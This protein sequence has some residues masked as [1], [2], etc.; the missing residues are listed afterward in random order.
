MHSATGSRRLIRQ[1]TTGETVEAALERCQRAT[2][3]SSDSMSRSIGLMSLCIG[4]KDA[5]SAENG[6]EYL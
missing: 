4:Q 2:T 1:Q 6:R 3:V 5:D